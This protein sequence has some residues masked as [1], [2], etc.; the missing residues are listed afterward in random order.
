M[1][2]A[3]GSNQQGQGVTLYLYNNTFSNMPNGVVAYSQTGANTTGQ[4]P[5]T[6]VL[7]N[8]TF[9]NMDAVRR[10]HGRAAY[11]STNSNSHVYSLVMNNIFSNIAGTAVQFEGMQWNS[12]LQYNLFNGNGTNVSATPGQGFVGNIGAKYGD[13]KFVDAAARNFALQAGSSAIDSARSEIG[14]NVAG[15]AIYP[16]VT[17]STSG[18]IYGPRTN[19]ATLT[20]TQQAGASNVFGGN[21]FISDTRQI[22]TLPGSGLFTFNDL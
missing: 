11:D 19:P 15:N 13:P 5:T 21:G 10:A 14:Q 16:T 2:G 18:L 6:L 8:N 7:L 22:V 9:Y 3:R 4:S 12:Q 20:G 17:Q 1:N